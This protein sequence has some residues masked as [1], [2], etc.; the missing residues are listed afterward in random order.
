MICDC[1]DVSRAALSLRRLSSCSMPL[2]ALHSHFIN[3]MLNC[4]LCTKKMT[5]YT[6]LLRD[7]QFVLRVLVDR[8][9]VVA[10]LLQGGLLLE[11][12]E[13]VLRRLYLLGGGQV[14]LARQTLDLG[15]ELLE[16]VDGG[17]H[18]C[19]H[20]D[21]DDDDDGE[22]DN[23]NEDDEDAAGL[24]PGVSTPRVAPAFSPSPSALPPAPR[25]YRV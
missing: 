12:C 25:R 24:S 11:Q 3:S 13:P 18:C 19:T 1:K 15:P 7:L 6:N 17:S 20:D 5:I 21:V 9:E 8:L 23:E 16:P 22:V 14:E 10:P 2:F 4:L